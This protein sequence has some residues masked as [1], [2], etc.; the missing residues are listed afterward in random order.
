MPKCREETSAW[1]VF[2]A[3]R[4]C[5]AR[6]CTV[7]RASHCSSAPSPASRVTA[8]PAGHIPHI[9]SLPSPA[10]EPA[11]ASRTLQ[12]HAEPC[13]MACR[14]PAAPLTCIPA[15]HLLHHL[16]RCAALNTPRALP[17]YAPRGPVSGASAGCSPS[18]DARFI[19]WL[20][21]F[22]PLLKHRLLRALPDSISSSIPCSLALTRLSLH[23]LP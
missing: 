9:R 6:L 15:T 3:E 18:W 13:F 1:T 20:P 21:S 8:Q 16:L 10:L 23:S 17:E 2:V 5:E 4:E 12:I 19:S 7:T 22:R 11:L 14:G